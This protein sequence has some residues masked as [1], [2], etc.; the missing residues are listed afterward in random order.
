MGPP[1]LG[2][3]RR[4]AQDQVTPWVAQQVGQVRGAAAELAQ[5]EGYPFH[6][7]ACEAPA[8]ELRRRISARQAGGKDA[9]EAT[10]A[11]LEQQFGWLEPLGEAER[12]RGLT[13]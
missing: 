9:S 4:S 2:P 10:L 8:D 7:L 1:R 6:I 3:P 5:A 11:V 13:A 12:A